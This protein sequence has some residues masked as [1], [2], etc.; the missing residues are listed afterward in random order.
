MNDLDIVDGVGLTIISGLMKAINDLLTFLE[1]RI[2]CDVVDN[3]C[4]TFNRVILDARCKTIISMLED[5]R[6][7]VM[8]RLVKNK[9]FVNT[10]KNDYGPRVLAKLEKSQWDISGVPCLYAFSSII[11]EGGD[12][13]II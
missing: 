1:Q 10:W 2:K 13:N 9:Q 12:P 8:R 6:V 5:I 11:L 7:Y 4:E 3:M